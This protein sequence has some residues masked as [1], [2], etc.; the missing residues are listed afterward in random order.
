MYTQP[1]PFYAAQ[2]EQPTVKTTISFPKPA[3]KSGLYISTAKKT[4]LANKPYICV[5][6]I[7][8]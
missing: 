1:L 5:S 2:S 3:T 6:A 8:S 7:K 4:L